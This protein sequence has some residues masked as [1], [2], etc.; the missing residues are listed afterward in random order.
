M[1]KYFKIFIFL[2]FPILAQ[3]QATVLSSFGGY[4]DIG[5]VT[6]TGPV[7][8]ITV[9]GFVG[10][11]RFQADGPY[12]AFDVSIGDVLWADC[13]RFVVM[14]ISA[15]T[16]SSVILTVEVPANDW[17]LGVGVPFNGT[18]CALVHEEIG[19]LPALP[20]PAD[21]NAG[22]L[23]GIDVN[24]YA[25]M[26]NH[27]NQS[28]LTSINSL[29]EI[30][31]YTGI[32]DVIP[33]VA[34][35]TTTGQTW[36]NSV[37]QLYYS[38][39]VS[40]MSDS[41]VRYSTTSLQG[42]TAGLYKI[43]IDTVGVD[44]MYINNN[45]TFR[46]FEAGG[47]VSQSCLDTITITGIT[48]TPVLGTAMVRNGTVWDNI[49]GYVQST[50]PDGMIS[51]ILSPTQ[52]IVQYCGSFS[53][54]LATG[55][56]YA[57][58]IS[59]TGSTQTPP[60]SGFV[61]PLG[62]V[63]GGQFIVS[64]LGT[65][66]SAG[67]SSGGGST[68]VLDG[69]T[70]DF[71]LTGQQLTG[72]VKVQTL[73]ST[74]I[75]VGGIEL[76]GLSQDGAAIGQIL[77]W[78]GTAWVPDTDLAREQKYRLQSTAP[79]TTYTWIDQ[80][81]AVSNVAD[82]KDYVL[83]EWETI[84]YFDITS[85]AY[86]NTPPLYVLSS[87][88]SNATSRDGGGNISTNPLST[89]F[90]YFTNSWEIASPG[91]AVFKPQPNC[92]PCN[93]YVTNFAKAANV[94]GRIVKI[95]SYSFGNQSIGQWADPP[96]SPM[97]DSL[98][99]VL[100]NSGIP[101][102][103]VFL[104]FQ[105]E[106]DHLIPPAAYPPLFQNVLDR[107]A[108]TG[109]FNKR[110]TPVL[111]AEIPGVNNAMNEAFNFL[112]NDT[113]SNIR[114]VQTRDLPLIDTDHLSGTGLEELGKRFYDVFDNGLKTNEDIW[115]YQSDF[116]AYNT[117]KRNIGIGGEAITGVK[118]NVIGREITVGTDLVTANADV[119][120]LLDGTKNGY[121]TMH[122]YLSTAQRVM[123]IGGF[124]GSNNS[125]IAFGGGSS[126]HQPAQ[127][128]SFWTGAFGTSGGTPKMNV[129]PSGYVWVRERLGINTFSGTERLT[130]DGNV[131]IRGTAS[132]Y[133]L[134]KN[135]FLQADVDQFANNAGGDY[136]TLRTPVGKG[137]SLFVA[138]SPAAGVVV[139]PNSN[140]GINRN[141]PLNTLHVGNPAVIGTSGVRHSVANWFSTGINADG[142]GV[143][144]DAVYF[145][146][147]LSVA[148][149]ITGTLSNAQIAQQ[150]ATTG[151]ALTWNGTDWVPTTLETVPASIPANTFTGS[152][153]SA[154]IANAVLAGKVAGDKI[155]W[156]MGAGNGISLLI[157]N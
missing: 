153:S 65:V 102:V 53:T 116:K 92:F 14:G 136:Y 135:A 123:A 19:L 25:C 93:N 118:L 103:D 86:S 109:K 48:P 133:L 15:P 82:V 9:T 154:A 84:G 131:D 33:A 148:G 68:T 43:G 152:T 85:K 112:A 80:S 119:S 140:V 132:P 122:P 23:S 59:L 98:L 78:N 21:G 115:S 74:H 146:S 39:G 8:T 10:S 20:S 138:G 125:E 28:L 11:P 87:G 22:S 156:N 77:R 2:L 32:K 64:S 97:G 71:T 31:D 83:G 6:G 24:L 42:V 120:T 34:A 30:V 12:A 104:W 129:D 88:Q 49:S 95:V 143:E 47:S 58:S 29:N 16:L 56:Y 142:D 94:D 67:G 57:D 145:Q 113:M 73:D 7:F 106:S 36:R 69:T 40:W 61:R 27:Y 50:A 52:A 72:E 139:A 124:I 55:A 147:N 41:D 141:V 126:G 96:P 60:T 157:V 101:R 149:D 45:G 26:Q 76:E 117:L 105:G 44:T 63:A 13:A 150:G 111:I 114:V 66:F 130:V 79:D 81:T 3:S 127:N 38:D 54:T 91:N 37:G 137:I 18:R 5:T 155:W 128:V 70:L 121:F 134:L 4:G 62:H 51:S 35:S 1:I 90:N 151:Q 89:V 99:L 108:T 110:R 144:R 46:R 107:L 100:N 75:K 17:A